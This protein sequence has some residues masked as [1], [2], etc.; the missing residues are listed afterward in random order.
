MVFTDINL[1]PAKNDGQPSV[2]IKSAGHFDHSFNNQGKR[3]SMLGITMLITIEFMIS[4]KFKVPT[5]QAYGS[6]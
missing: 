4:S 1:V 6:Q 3:C 2:F 5:Y